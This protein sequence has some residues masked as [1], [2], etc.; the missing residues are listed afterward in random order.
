M[1][2]L[3][4]FPTHRPA[5][6][7]TSST[8]FA[9]APALLAQIAGTLTTS[10]ILFASALLETGRL[11]SLHILTPLFHSLLSISARAWESTEK[12]RDAC[13]FHFMVWIL[14][15]YA[16]ALFIF[17]PGWIVVGAIWLLLFGW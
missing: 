2:M 11:L 5:L 7:R 12:F 15:P 14:N 16:V 1:Q 6:S 13:F 3:T 8:S 10:L 17:W 9:F 4:T